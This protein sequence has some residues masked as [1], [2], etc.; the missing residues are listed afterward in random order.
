MQLGSLISHHVLNT[1]AFDESSQ[2]SSMHGHRGEALPVLIKELLHFIMTIWAIGAF[3]TSK[4]LQNYPSVLLGFYLISKEVILYF[5]L[6]VDCRTY[7]I[8]SIK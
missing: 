7:L 3:N 4:F 2:T 8:A 1:V 5:G 6:Q